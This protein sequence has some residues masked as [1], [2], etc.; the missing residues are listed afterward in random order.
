MGFSKLCSMPNGNGILVPIVLSTVAFALSVRSSRRCDLFYREVTFPELNGGFTEEENPLVDVIMGVS[1]NVGLWGYEQD[2]GGCYTYAG[3]VPL[4]AA[5]VCARVC[6][7]LSIL[8]GG[9]CV[10]FLWLTPCIGLQP[11][12]AA[13]MTLTCLLTCFFQGMTLLQ[14]RSAICSDDY[15]ISNGSLVESDCSLAKGAKCGAAA[16]VLWFVAAIAVCCMP[17]PEDDLRGT[18]I[19]TANLEDGTMTETPKKKKKKGDGA[20]DQSIEVTL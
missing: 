15:T 10:L 12:I 3:G 11:R 5:L 7:V 4:D 19:L 17:A 6:S 20:N 14:K 1:R 9:S 18:M 13:I 8:V 2:N 16:T